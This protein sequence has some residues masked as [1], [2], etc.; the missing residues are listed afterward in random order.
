MATFDIR[1]FGAIEIRR[2]GLLLTDF[3][4]QKA[5]VLLAYLICENRPVT[6]DFLAGLAWPEMEQSQALGLLRRSLH[7][8]NNQLP[9]CLATERRTVHFSPTTPTTVDIQTFTTLMAANDLDGW[10]TAAACYR[11]PFLQGIYVD[12]APELENW[13]LRTQEHWQQVAMQALEQIIQHHTESSAYALA[14]RYVQQLLALAPWREEAQRQAMLLLARTGQV[15]AALA[16]YERCRQILQ[17]ELAV[18]PDPETEWLYTRLKAVAHLPP[19]NLPASTTPFIGRAEELTDLVRL[20]ANRSSRLIT[21]LGP[22]G[23]GKTRLALAVARHVITEQQRVFLHGV[24]FVALAD[25]DT[26]AQFVSTLAQAL[27]LTVQPQSPAA[28]QVYHYLR[29]KELLLVLDNFE[30]LVEGACLAFVTKLL[31]TAP[32]VKLLITSRVRLNLQGEQLYW[33]QGLHFPAAQANREP[34]PLT[35]LGQY[36]GMQLFLEASRRVQPDYLLTQENATAIGTICQ[37]VQGMPLAIELAAAWIC[38]L[39]PAEIVAE[40]SRNLDFLASEMHD[41]PLRQRSMRVVFDTSWRLLRPDEQVVLQQLAVFHGGFTR[42]AAQSVTGASLPLLMSLVHKSFLSKSTT[43]RFEIH[44]L[45]RRYA[46]DKLVQTAD[47]STAVRDRHTTYY[48]AYLA[49][50]PSGWGRAAQPDVVAF[51]HDLANL[52]AAWLWAVDQL[53]VEPLAQMMNKLAH[54]YDVYRPKPDGEAIFRPAAEK[55][56]A[57]VV[58]ATASLNTLHVYATVCL[59]LA[60]ILMELS[61]SAEAERWSQRSLL[62]WQQLAHLGQDTKV[63]QTMTLRNL[64]RLAFATHRRRAYTLFQDGLALAQTVD[65]LL[66]RSTLLNDLA[67]ASWCLGHYREAQQWSEQNLALQPRLNN[68]VA[69]AWAFNVLGIITLHRGATAEAERLQRDSL[70]LFQAVGDPGGA[71][72]ALTHLG[73]TLVWAGKTAAGERILAERILRYRETLTQD[74]LALAHQGWSEAW[75]HLGDYARAQQQATTALALVRDLNQPY[76]T[77]LA[78]LTLGQ[79]YLALGLVQEGHAALQESVAI[80]QAL[81]QQGALGWA[82]AALGYSTLRLGDAGQAQ[83]HLG[84]ALQIAI[85]TTVFFP[86]LMAFPALALLQLDQGRQAQAEA[87]YTQV[88]QFPLVATSRW[89]ADVAGHRLAPMA[90]TPTVAGLPAVDQSVD[91]W[92]TAETLLQRLQ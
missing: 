55:L 26:A 31:Q 1:L 56:L 38:L 36:S 24:H 28:D 76:P 11:A 87:L 21:L 46:T 27:A 35:D 32:D 90:T 37:L 51:L 15:S 91:L 81:E 71:A 4:S 61:R 39:P 67:D 7:D 6:R 62:G 59:Y 42:A 53:Q 33:L 66:T 64:G 69:Q 16:Q 50:F 19:P 14:L 18:A 92:K 58:L 44:E 68:K 17:T 45:V 60:E 49:Q 89:F 29:D 75:L 2:D 77:G 70:Q 34:L 65:N 22:G 74:Y 9:D 82:L 23:I 3:R 79:A 72:H 54:F 47:K 5:L 83:Q 57:T 73:I 20:L 40:I 10:T 86:L 85:E 25:T 63:R 78:L 30:Q 84:H 52:R 13:L 48:A 8:L 41:L 80:F 43:D 88:A 12:D